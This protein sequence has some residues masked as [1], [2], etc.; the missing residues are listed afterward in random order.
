V[1]LQLLPLTHSQAQ[2]ILLQVIQF[3]RFEFK[4]EQKSLCKN[5]YFLDPFVSSPNIPVFKLDSDVR[6][7]VNFDK[8]VPVQNRTNQGFDIKNKKKNSFRKVNRNKPLNW[9]SLGTIRNYL[10]VKT[11]GIIQ[12]LFLEEGPSRQHEAYTSTI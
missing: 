7:R 8:W 6:G 9:V 1:R 2:I 10:S 3:T 11:E 5:L 4:V 12:Y